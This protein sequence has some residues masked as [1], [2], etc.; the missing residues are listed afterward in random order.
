MGDRAP[1]GTT[2][3]F[4]ISHLQGTAN[5]GIVLGER[6][7]KGL[8]GEATHLALDWAFHVLG[9]QNVLLEALAWSA[10]ALRA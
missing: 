10:A 6:R 1:V 9:L 2:S 3:L 7:N 4:S 8:G 5:F